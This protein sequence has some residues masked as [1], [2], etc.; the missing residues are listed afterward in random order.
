MSNRP[1]SFQLS[2]SRRQFTKGSLAAGALAATAVAGAFPASAQDKD[3][4][5]DALM[6]PGALPDIT[7]GDK[8]AK[9]VMVEYASMSCPYC[10]RFHKGVLPALKEKYIDTGKVLLIMREFPLNRTALAVSM[11][12]RCAGSNDKTA[13]L[14]D[15]YFDKQDQWL[16]RG[17]IAKK[18]LDIGKQVGFTEDS[19]NK[20]LDDKELANKLVQQREKASKEFGVSATPT[21]F[22]NG[23][24][25]RGN[26][27]NIATFES[28]IDP[29]LKENS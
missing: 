12:T 24:R 16:I 3:V 21:V 19:F 25:V 17:D 1:R 10:A 23:K 26:I 29:L 28:M 13:A 9:V 5:V 6:A 15:I 4:E 14:V 2:P 18:L 8:N 27:L 11:L 20:C 22:I 7:V